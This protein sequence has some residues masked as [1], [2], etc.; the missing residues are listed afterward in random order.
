VV[1]RRDDLDFGTFPTVRVVLP[2][3]TRFDLWSEMSLWRAAG[4]SAVSLTLRVDNVAAAR[5]AEVHG[6][7]APGRRVLVGVRAGGAP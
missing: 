2:A 4:G 3:Y 7:P 1:G 5:Y 6:F